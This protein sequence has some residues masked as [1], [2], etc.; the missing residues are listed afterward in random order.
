MRSATANERRLSKASLDGISTNICPNIIVW[1]ERSFWRRRILSQS[2][3]LTE[4]RHQA[5]VA[6][7]CYLMSLKSGG[8]LDVSEVTRFSGSFWQVLWEN[9]NWTEYDCNFPY[10]SF[11][12]IL[13]KISIDPSC[14]SFVEALQNNFW[15][16][17]RK[18]MRYDSI[19]DFYILGKL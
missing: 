14:I 7:F 8:F 15:S 2:L 17:S 12:K 1:S 18:N 13:A 10:H 5:R 11:L 16:T 3:H 4:H 19:Y 6:R 9:E